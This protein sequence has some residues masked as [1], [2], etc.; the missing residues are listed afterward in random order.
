MSTN[1]ATFLLTGGRAN[2]LLTRMKR[3]ESMLRSTGEPPLRG[4]ST[5]LVGSAAVTITVS[6]D[7]SPG[8]GAWRQ[9]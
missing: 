8:R 7:G 3:G 9:L 6:A 4:A 2:D 1:I 5:R